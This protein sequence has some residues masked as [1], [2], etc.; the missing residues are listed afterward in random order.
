MRST[1]LLTIEP[2]KERVAACLRAGAD[3]AGCEV[4]VEWADPAYADM[5]DNPALLDCY[6]ANLGAVGRVTVA[7]SEARVVGQ[8]RHGQREL[9]RSLHTS[10]D[11]GGPR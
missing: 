6:L 8:H 1:N 4:D 3:A 10:H 11:Q 9:H 7:D 5:N 2:L